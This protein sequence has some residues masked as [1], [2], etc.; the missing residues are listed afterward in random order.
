MDV[1]IEEQSKQWA[2]I[3]TNQAK[4]KKSLNK[5]LPAC[6]KGDGSCF[7]GTGKE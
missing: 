4:K 2:H 6:Q 7:A 1:E 5:R 3:F